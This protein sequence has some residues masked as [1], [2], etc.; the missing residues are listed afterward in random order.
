MRPHRPSPTQC[1][2]GSQ[3]MM[4][5][6]H[7]RSR[8]SCFLQS[9][10]PLCNRENEETW[11]LNLVIE[12]EK[13]PASAAT[14]LFVPPSG[15]EIMCS[16]PSLIFR[17]CLDNAANTNFNSGYSFPAKSTLNARAYTTRSGRSEDIDENRK[18][19]CRDGTVVDRQVDQAP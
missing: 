11:S 9:Q 12:Q 3:A 6:M 7:P 14:P 1:W 13:P 8:H 19:M 15:R 18:E 10:Q 5:V 17:L 4:V 2:Y 16:K